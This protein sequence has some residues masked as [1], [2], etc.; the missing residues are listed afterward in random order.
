MLLAPTT[1]FI[2]LFNA[3]SGCDDH[4]T[5]RTKIQDNKS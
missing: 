3:G 2:R 4:S 5:I 1:V